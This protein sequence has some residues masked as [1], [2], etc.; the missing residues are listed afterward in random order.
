MSKRSEKSKVGSRESEGRRSKLRAA[1]LCLLCCVGCFAP[2]CD[3]SR[4][5]G[6]ADPEASREAVRARFAA[7]LP[8]RKPEG[9]LRLAISSV[10]LEAE[11]T[12]VRMT[13]YAVGEAA[14]FDLPQYLMSRGR[15][16]INER[17]RTYLLDEA[18]REYRLKDRRLTVGEVP[19]DGR[20]KV[21]AGEAR[22]FTLTFPRLPDGVHGGALVYGG[23]VL[24]FYLLP[25]APTAR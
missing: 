15:W 7:C 21:G 22:E 4:A 17:A 18:C 20:V 9:A 1:C 25:A 12:S 11:Q 3:R 10:Q 2:G 14:D 6:D 8:E 5:R 19:Q 24:P 23:W 16:L 13:A